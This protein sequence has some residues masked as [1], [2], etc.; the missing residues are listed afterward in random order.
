M[1]AE[2]HQTG[3]GAASN[4]TYPRVERIEEIQDSDK[5]PL[6]GTFTYWFKSKTWGA[7]GANYEN[8]LKVGT[9]FSTVSKVLIEMI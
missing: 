8:D 7:G 9:S 4:H 1:S 6:C 5:T 3:A 2:D